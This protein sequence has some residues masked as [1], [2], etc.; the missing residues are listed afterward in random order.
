[1]LR[2][3]RYFG[4]SFIKHKL[5]SKIPPFPRLAQKYSM[6]VAEKKSK[7]LSF[8][9]GY[10]NEMRIDQ[11]VSLSFFGIAYDFFGQAP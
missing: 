4:D 2:Q 8:K 9:D 1:M 7:A 3:R 10:G 5:V 11:E 6:R